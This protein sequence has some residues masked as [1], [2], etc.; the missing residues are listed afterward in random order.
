MKEFQLI[1]KF[2]KPLAENQKAARGLEDDVAQISD[3]V[4]SKDM[5]VE[6]VHF[7]RADGGFKIASKLLRTNLSDLAS[8]GATPLY[9]MLG[10]SKNK[11]TDEKFLRDFA[12][13]LKSVQSEFGLYLIGGDTVTSEKLFFSVTIF[14]KAKNGK[15]LSRNSAKNGDLIYVSGTIGD[16]FLGRTQ[17]LSKYFLDRHFFP[18]PRIKLGEK[19]LTKNLAK[20][21]IDVSDGLLADLQHLCEASNLSAEINLEKIPFSKNSENPLELISA[22]DDY[23]LIF[24]TNPKNQ[25]K[26]SALAKEIK[27]DLSCIGKFTEAKKHKISLYQKGKKIKITQLGYEH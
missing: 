1:K 24:S 25:K 18:T 19:L 13:G 14:G 20:C 21:A 27:L 11:N 7:L 23:E 6:D 9:Y 2:F 4:I 15:V 22:G 12:R 3:L 8:A 26:I 17:K 16:A 5:F 10:F